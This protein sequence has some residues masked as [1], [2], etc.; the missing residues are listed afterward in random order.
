MIKSTKST[1]T[2][3]NT[4]K[5]NTLHLF[6]TEYKRVTTIF[7]DLLWEQDKVSSLLPKE[8]TSQVDT[9]LSARVIQ[10]AG[11]Q[12]SGIVRGTRKKQEKRLHIIKKLNK[13]GKYK[14]AKKLKAIYDTN[15][16]S[17]PVINTIEAELDSRFVKINLDNSTTF[18]GW[19]T[20]TSLGNKLSIKLPFKKHKHFIKMLEKG[21]IKE[22]VR[23]SDTTC[24]F[25][26]ELPE[27]ILKSEGKTL[28]I[29][30]GQKTTLSCSN[31]KTVETDNHGHTY[32]SIC[33]KLARKKK[34]SKSF[35]RTKK[36][37]SNYI[38]W[39]VNQ[40]DL[41]E[42]KQINL[43]NIKYLRK[44]KRTSRSLSHWNYKELF[45][46]LES[47]IIDSGVL[48]NKLNPTYTSQRCSLCGWVRKGNRKLKRFKCDKC[49]YTADSDL[50]ASINLSLN[51]TPIS[52]KKR[53][54]RS[55]RTGFYWNEVGQ[56]PIVSDALKA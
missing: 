39:C 38:R 47:K 20:L 43:E 9:W 40:I 42:I 41:S 28:G 45:D 29:D 53:L 19:I 31:G 46:K 15:H 5:L 48:I 7:V 32:K 21:I 36:H 49:G 4:N 35:I 18:D 54:L 10:C 6:L 51:L 25:M 2:F 52:D 12:A 44:G 26:F 8:I 34:G 50:N 33:D 37:R 27:P 1:L 11:K 55:N 23:L 13:E 30:I 3:S 16:A 56:E 14:K 22:G 17:K 24:T